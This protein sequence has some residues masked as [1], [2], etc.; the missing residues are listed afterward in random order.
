MTDDEFVG[1]FW[2]VRFTGLPRCWL[3]SFCAM[4]PSRSARSRVCSRRNK[5]SN[6]LARLL[7]ASYAT[8]AG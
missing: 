7:C 3:C 6:A 2:S 8:V 1:W 5:K 4:V